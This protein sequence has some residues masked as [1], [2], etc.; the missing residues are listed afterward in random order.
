MT[1]A[2][3]RV[4][5]SYNAWANRRLFQAAAPHPP[6][7]LRRDLAASH[8]SVWGTLLHIVWGEWLWLG[9]WQTAPAPGR[10]PSDS[11]SLPELE[12]RCA[13]IARQQLAFIDGLS[14]T[15]LDRR[16]SYENPPGT[17]WTYAIGDMV[18]HVMNHSTYHRGHAAA[19]L[20]QLGGTPPATD[21]LLFF[22]AGAPGPA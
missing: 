18:R 4:L 21:Y 8:G 22:D 16:I 5:L 20:R 10:N 1:R 9:R 14:E 7:V 2:E 13:E 17:I 15:D 12:A 6:D 3:A 11:R 19:L